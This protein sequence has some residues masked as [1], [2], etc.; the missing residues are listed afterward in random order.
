MKQAVHN[1]FNDSYMYIKIKMF[2]LQES[3]YTMQFRPIRNLSLHVIT[4]LSTIVGRQSS[5]AARISD[6]TR[7]QWTWKVEYIQQS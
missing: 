4:V 6:I 1:T 3:V 5:F 2:H 7:G